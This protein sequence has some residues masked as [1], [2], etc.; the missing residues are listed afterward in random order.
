MLTLARYNEPVRMTSPTDSQVTL[1]VVFEVSQAETSHE[2]SASSSNAVDVHVADGD[3][4]SNDAYSV[5]VSAH[6]V[7]HGSRVGIADGAD[8]E[9]TVDVGT[10][11]AADDGF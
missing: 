8:V 5:A 7:R 2:V 10:S 11:V 9:R 3:A 4:A 6:D 1:A